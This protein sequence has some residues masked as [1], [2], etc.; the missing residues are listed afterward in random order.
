MSRYVNKPHGLI[1]GSGNWFFY[2]DADDKCHDFP[3]IVGIDGYVFDQ[4]NTINVFVRTPAQ[5]LI[6]V[7]E[8]IEVLV[9]PFEVN[10]KLITDYVRYET[11]HHLT[12]SAKHWLEKNA[13]GYGFAGH[14]RDD[15]H[16]SIFFAK[17]SHALAF[18]KWVDDVLKG[19]RIKKR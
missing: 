5:Q 3:C 10:G 12:P 18:C 11:R 16:P 19:I 9:D 2:F 13:P 6:L 1:I 15:R 8:T 17:R 4:Y 7:Q 14:L